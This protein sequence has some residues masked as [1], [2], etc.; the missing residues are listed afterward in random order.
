MAPRYGHMLTHG[1]VIATLKAWPA[2]HAGQ[3]VQYTFSCSERPTSP[4]RPGAQW[5]ARERAETLRRDSSVS[6]PLASR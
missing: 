1:Y 3:A 2:A 4:C 6:P 5:N